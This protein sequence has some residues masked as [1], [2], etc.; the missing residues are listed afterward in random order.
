M[1]NKTQLDIKRTWHPTAALLELLDEHM[2]GEA[3]RHGHALVEVVA[4]GDEVTEPPI[5]H[6]LLERSLG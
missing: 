6:S 2:E 1:L 4:D 3:G 5:G